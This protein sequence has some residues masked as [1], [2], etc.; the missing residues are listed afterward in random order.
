MYAY[1]TGSTHFQSI[2]TSKKH[3]FQSNS[4]QPE[5]AC[6]P[7]SNYK[8]TL[9]YLHSYSIWKHHLYFLWNIQ[10]HNSVRY[11]LL[12]FIS[13][14]P[15]FI[16]YLLDAFDTLSHL[17]PRFHFRNLFFV[18]CLWVDLLCAWPLG[19]LKF[20]CN[21]DQCLHRGFRRCPKCYA[22]TIRSTWFHCHLNECQ[23]VAEKHSCCVLISRFIPSLSNSR[24]SLQSRYEYFKIE[25]TL[26][27]LCD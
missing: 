12:L 11:H 16:C 23:Q 1:Y 19:V 14:G 22:E 27:S 21:L 3:Q 24:F 5:A 13:W 4:L 10:C 6:C 20:L 8:L 15:W 7:V 25:S 18:G 26:K 9:E 2:A 17:F